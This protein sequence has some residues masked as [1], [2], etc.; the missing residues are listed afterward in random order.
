MFPVFASS[1]AA[2]MPKQI[3]DKS[4][5]SIRIMG[6]LLLAVATGAAVTPVAMAAH[7]SG[8]AHSHSA[9][10]RSI[11]GSFNPITRART[12]YSH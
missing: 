7:Q 8:G 11:T 3:G 1:M 10:W 4:M 2:D 12:R 9:H 5:K 6:A